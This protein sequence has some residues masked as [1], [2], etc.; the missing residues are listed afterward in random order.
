M[1]DVPSIAQYFR[2]YSYLDT[3]ILLKGGHTHPTNS[4]FL[5][6]NLILEVKY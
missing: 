4:Y 2:I 3:L 6:K 1:M 5:L